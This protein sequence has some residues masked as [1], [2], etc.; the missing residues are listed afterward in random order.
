MDETEEISAF[1]STEQKKSLMKGRFSR[2]GFSTLAAYGAMSV[3]SGILAGFVA[4]IV[5]MF[6]FTTVD[7]TD[8]LDLFS[9]GDISS[10]FGKVGSLALALATVFGSGVGLLVG[11]LIAKKIMGKVETPI[12]K[13]SLTSKE[14]LWVVLASFGAWGVG[15]LLGNITTT[16]GLPVKIYD[17]TAGVFGNNM[18][19]FYV[20]AIIGAPVMEELMFRK[21]LLNVLHRFG[22]APAAIA[23]A[24]LFGLLHGNSK[25]F[26]LAFGLGIIFAVVYMNTGKIKYTIFLHMMINTFAT[27]PDL[28]YMAVESDIVYVIWSIIS[29]VLTVTGVIFIIIGIKKMMFGLSW[30]CEYAFP[31]AVL[32][33]AG[34]KICRIAGLILICISDLTSIVMSCILSESILPFIDIISMVLTIMTVCVLTSKLNEYSVKTETAEKEEE[35]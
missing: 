31:G 29:L 20:Y 9:T 14:I 4:A 28:I 33:N 13:R 34:M 25:Q 3:V 32:G 10:I 22:R 2:A 24:L 12:E 11:I 19:V 27:L 26:F 21:T 7:T 18:A 1:E 30:S 23:S 6:R 17:S 8:L 5:M 16:L 35:L 15:A